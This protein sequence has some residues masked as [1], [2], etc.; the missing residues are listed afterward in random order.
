MEWRM[1]FLHDM[2]CVYCCGV[3]TFVYSLSVGVNVCVCVC[4]WLYEYVFLCGILLMSL[5]NYYI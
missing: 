1:K 2:L 5:C 3:A 4:V